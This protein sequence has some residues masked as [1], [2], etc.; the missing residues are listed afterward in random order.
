MRPM[1]PRIRPVAQ[2]LIGL[3]VGLHEQA[4]HTDRD[5][6]SRERRDELT[7]P[8]P[9]PTLCRRATAPNASRQTQPGSRSPS[10]PPAETHIGNQVIVTEAC[11]PFAHHNVLVAHRTHLC[12]DV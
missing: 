12:N 2:R 11:S 8:V 4:R 3:R 10:S 5:R 9:T 6:R 1:G 7:L